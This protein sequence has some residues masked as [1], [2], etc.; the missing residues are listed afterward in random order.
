M[1][2]TDTLLEAAEKNGWRVRTENVPREVRDRESMLERDRPTHIHRLSRGDQLAII[3]CTPAYDAA[4][5]HRWV[6]G[7]R[8]IGQ[9]LGID[10]RP[11][12]MEQLLAQITARAAN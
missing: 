11:T 12:Q 3:A 9:T 10:G 8:R 5:E 2:F 7:N 1:L 6:R 4:H